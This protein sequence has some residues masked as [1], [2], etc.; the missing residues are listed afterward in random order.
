MLFNEPKLL[1]VDDQADRFL[2]VGVS[3]LFNEPKL[4]KFDLRSLP[5]PCSNPYYL[6]F[7]APEPSCRFI[8]TL[9]F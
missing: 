1:K 4:L 3:V 5:R 7:A 9:V 6:H 8:S 2:N